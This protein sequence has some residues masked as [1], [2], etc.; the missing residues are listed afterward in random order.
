MDFKQIL[1]E[2]LIEQ[3]DFGVG[4]FLKEEQLDETAQ[5]MTLFAPMVMQALNMRPLPTPPFMQ[6]RVSDPVWSKLCAG[7]KQLVLVEGELGD[8]KL[9]RIV[10][11]DFL[12][13]KGKDVPEHFTEIVLGKDATSDALQARL[14]SPR[15]VVTLQTSNLRQL[16]KRPYNITRYILQ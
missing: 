16:T 6:N 3:N 2:A 14:A 7:C 4:T 10:A 8:E 9:A 5:G 12:Y 15:E 11:F 13:Q 1:E